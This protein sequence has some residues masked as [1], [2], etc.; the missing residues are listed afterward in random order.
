MPTNHF[1]T[2]DFNNYNNRMRK[3]WSTPL[4]AGVV[5]IAL[6]LIAIMPFFYYD[7]QADV[8]GSVL[9]LGM[10]GVGIGSFVIGI[11]NFKNRRDDLWVR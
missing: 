5:L 3:R 4:L 6:A 9:L 10:V 1:I 11:K 8:V 7:V 2:E